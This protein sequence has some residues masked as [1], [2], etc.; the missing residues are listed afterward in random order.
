M[1]KDIKENLIELISK[2]LNI[3]KENIKTRDSFT[4]DLKADSLDVVEII[5]SVEEEFDISIPDEK[6]EKMETIQHLIDYIK[7]NT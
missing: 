6:A 2:Q 5:M 3:E 4:K 1:S 7:N